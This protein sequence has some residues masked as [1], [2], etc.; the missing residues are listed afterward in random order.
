MKSINRWLRVI[1]MQCASVRSNSLLDERMG[2]SMVDRQTL[3]WVQDEDLLQEILQLSD[4]AELV[5]RHPLATDHVRHQVLAW[6]DRAHHR[7]FF[8]QT[9]TRHT[10]TLL[11]IVSV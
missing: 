2:Q 7:H 5:F 8:L 1:H 3:C 6:T 4:L 9:A 10:P 11:S